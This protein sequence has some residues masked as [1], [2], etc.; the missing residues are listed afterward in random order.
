[1]RKSKT[2][3]I[4]TVLADYLEDMG[5]KNRLREIAVIKQW[6]KL[7]GKTIARATGNIYIKDQKLFLSINSVVIKNEI[8]LLKKDIIRRFN[9]LAGEEMVKDIVLR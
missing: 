1:M 8:Y 4:K 6:E 9:E 3:N 5:I 7:M 2:L